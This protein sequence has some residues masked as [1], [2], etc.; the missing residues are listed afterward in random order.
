MS[1]ITD[2]IQVNFLTKRGQA[3]STLVYGVDREYADTDDGYQWIRSSLI[4][5]YNM[6]DSAENIVITTPPIPTG[7]SG[8]EP[9][10]VPAYMVHE[11]FIS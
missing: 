10:E 3:L 11:D 7:S 5:R 6:D 4:K 1:K 9:L 2:R 8:G